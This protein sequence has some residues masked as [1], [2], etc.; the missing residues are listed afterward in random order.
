MPAGYAGRER[1][2]LLIVNCLAEHGDSRF[3]W[4]YGYIESAGVVVARRLLGRHYRTIVALQAE[5]AT[6]VEFL[7]CLQNM[8]SDRAN[9]AV[10]LFFQVH[11]KP[12][13]ARFF[14][15]WAATSRLAE[16]I[17]I[18]AARGRLRLVYNL[19]CYGDSHSADFLKAGFR[20]SVGSRLVNASAGTEYPLFCRLWSGRGPGRKT[21]MPISEVLSRADRLLPRRIQDRVASRYFSD[22]DSKKIIWGNGTVTIHTGSGRINSS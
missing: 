10:D 6:R 14:D 7:S 3:R 1:R 8:S 15:Q 20:V 19:S 13:L 5:A 17:R 9:D 2:A 18:P 4:L 11:G 16:D 22:V 21:G 12:G